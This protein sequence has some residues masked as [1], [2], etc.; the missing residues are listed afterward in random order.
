MFALNKKGQCKMWPNRNM[1]NN[2][3]ERPLAQNWDM[4]REIVQMLTCLGWNNREFERVCL[5]LKKE[6]FGFEGLANV[7]REFR[8]K[9]GISVIERI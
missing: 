9:K 4:Y 6:D 5:D 8:S 2:E 7:V 3:P 1:A